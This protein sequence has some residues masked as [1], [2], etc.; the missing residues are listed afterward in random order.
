MRFTPSF[1]DQRGTAL[2]E[3][4][5]VLPIFLFLVIGMLHFGKAF[6]Y[7]INETH[8][9][10]EAARFAVVNKNPGGTG[11]TLQEYVRRQA[12]TDELKD[13]GTD[14]VPKSLEVCI[15]FPQ[16]QVVGAPV[17]VTVKTEYDWLPF[18][19][20]QL[21]GANV[22]VSGSATMRIE[23]PPTNYSAGCVGGVAT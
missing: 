10:N 21:S 19:K 23:V 6:N 11:I 5:L 9:A 8:L 17:T 3:F 16:G 18:L 22:T 20:N 12:E 14:S 13:G 4:A 7:W 15:A 1:R 2:V